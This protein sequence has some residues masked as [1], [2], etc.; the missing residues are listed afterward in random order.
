MSLLLK[1]ASWF[2]C[3][4]QSKRY[5]KL[6]TLTKGFQSLE[7][8]SQDDLP[9]SNQFE[10][11]DKVTETEREKLRTDVTEAMAEND[12][13][14]EETEEVLFFLFLSTVFMHNFGFSRNSE[15]YDMQ[16]SSEQNVC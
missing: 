3:T 4:L 7:Y 10:D 8:D 5:L 2:K 9:G 1:K 15:R 13:I 12:T 14:D 6:K 11:G 16:A